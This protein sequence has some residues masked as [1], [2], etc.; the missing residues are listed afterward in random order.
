MPRRRALAGGFLRQWRTRGAREPLARGP[1]SSPKRNTATRPISLAPGRRARTCLAT[2]LRRWRARAREPG[3]GFEERK[4]GTLQLRGLRRY[5]D[6]GA[7]RRDAFQRP[8]R[9]ADRGDTGA[10]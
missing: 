5:R 6:G 10:R 9:T 3:A 4:P 7:L 1:T 2:A 8:D